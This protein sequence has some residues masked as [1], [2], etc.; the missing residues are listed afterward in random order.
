MRSS[1]RR[2]LLGCAVVAVLGG[3]A[4]CSDCDPP[5]HA[6][7]PRRPDDRAVLG[8]RPAPEP[9]AS[10][11]APPP[12]APQSVAGAPFETTRWSPA[13]A[14]RRP[15]V[16]LL[17]G[18]GGP[19]FFLDRPEYA[20]YPQAL[21]A[22]GFVV[23]MPH[24]A[25]SGRAPAAAVAGIIDWLGSQADVDAQLGVIGF[26]RGGFIGSCVAGTDERVAAFA[27]CYGGLDGGCRA[28]ITRMPPTLVLHGEADP[29]VPVESAANLARFVQSHGAPAETKTYPGQEHIFLGDALD[30]SVT[31]IVGFFRAR[32][33][34]GG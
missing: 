10:D 13:G 25:Q 29:V 24:Y 3:A 7:R 6:P 26:S 19:G 16:V 9:P 5:T 1:V 27:S 23:L 8:A 28:R 15:V 20:R 32:L 33:A 30:D 21:A 2:C 22:A 14:G 34:R 18:A 12:V 4:A 11:A 17:H 31:R